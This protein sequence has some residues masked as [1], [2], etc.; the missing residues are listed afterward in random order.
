MKRFTRSSLVRWSTVALLMV[1]PGCGKDS[2]GSPGAA[3]SAGAGVDAGVD[4]VAEASA[5]AGEDAEPDQTSEDATTTDGG[6]IPRTCAQIGAN[7]GEAPDDC[8]GSIACGECPTGQTCGGGG[9]NQCGSA[10]CSARTCAQ[11]GT[12]CG[13]VS[14]GCS[15][16]I[17]CG[18][19]TAPETCGG[20]GIPFQCGCQCTLPNALTSCSST[21]CSVQSC[22]T[23]FADCNAVAADGCEVAITSDAMN[24]GVCGKACSFGN[25]QGICANGA[26]QLGA[27]NDGYSNCD[28]QA[29]NGCEANT[30]VNPLH[31]GTCNHACPSSGGKPV[32]LNGSCDISDCDAGLGD[33]DNDKT[34]GCE[35][36]LL[37]GWK[38]CGQ[39]GN[40]CNL[41]NS[42]PA[43]NGGVCAIATCD[44]GWGNCD[45]DASNGCETSLETSPQHCGS[46]DTACPDLAGAMAT[47]VGGGCSYVCGKFLGDCDGQ[48]LTGCE[49][50][51]QTTTDCGECGLKCSFANSFASCDVGN[52]MFMSCKPGFGD[53]N[54]YT[55][56]GCERDLNNDS[57]HCGG[58][59]HQCVPNAY[60]SAGECKCAKPFCGL[61]CCGSNQKCCNSEQC[62]PNTM[63]CPLPQ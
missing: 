30:L 22:E 43:C 28:Q 38:N 48:V 44:P 24:C 55:P 42:S 19:C 41:A 33:C 37:T 61:M 51:L 13:K 4:A 60:C 20:A 10:P 54:K 8:G 15:G 3:G 26:C 12:G 23:G 32:C 53:C 40:L 59:S 34:N 14:D 7:C 1:A 58:C 6:C 47:C 49:T 36:N 29:P 39:C 27:C 2:A 50:S 9:K 46:C 25:A 11:T 63:A 18:S 52:C 31:C 56:D 16:V 57:A 62:Y 21:G 17:D 35:T 5:E 45:G